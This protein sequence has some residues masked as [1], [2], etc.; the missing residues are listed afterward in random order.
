MEEE[1][2]NSPQGDKE[3]LNEPTAEV[4]DEGV[5]IE[6]PHQE[7][8]D[9]YGSE[10]ASEY[11][12]L[13]S[14]ISIQTVDPST[15]SNPSKLQIL[16]MYKKD[17]CMLVIMSIFWPSCDVY[18]DLLLFIDLVIR[19]EVR[20]ATCLLLPQLVNIILT[21]LLW[22]KLE[23]KE[24]RSWS[25]ILVPLQ[26][27]PQFFALR[28][29]WNMLLG[30]EEWKTSKLTLTNQI[31]TLE[32]YTESLPCVYILMT[33]WVYEAN[34]KENDRWGT[35]GHGRDSYSYKI[36][37]ASSVF[38]IFSSNFGI[39]KFF[40][41]SPVR[42]LPAV[43]PLDGYLAPKTLITFF[44]VLLLNTLKLLYLNLFLRVRVAERLLYSVRGQVCQQVTLFYQSFSFQRE[45]Y[46][47]TSTVQGLCQFEI[48]SPV[49]GKYGRKIYTFLFHEIN[50]DSWVQIFNSTC[51][52]AGTTKEEFNNYTKP[53][54]T[55][56]FLLCGDWMERADI[57]PNL[58]IWLLVFI[59]PH[60]LLS[61]LAL[62][63][64]SGSCKGFTHLLVNQPQIIF[65]PAFS[66][67]VFATQKDSPTRLS[68]SPGFSWV[69]FLLHI[70]SSIA[71]LPLLL[72]LFGDGDILSFQ[73]THRTVIIWTMVFHILS[74]ICLALVLHKPF[75]G[76]QASNLKIF[77]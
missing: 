6:S 74:P 58:L 44:S 20:Y 66:H 72:P 60:L 3:G 52:D 14:S 15:S 17:V 46:N 24:H 55:G 13:E 43:G 73:R 28:I 62:K 36:F 18:S 56:S 77:R 4:S 47:L 32:P 26:A 76:A 54:P 10:V 69:N 22:R 71:V 45:L 37:F 61:L 21:A 25:W 70:I 75:K 5:P 64:I 12:N 1:D 40:K 57:V 7:V 30:K 33:L 34:I 16:L 31:N 29:I 39:I 68:L 50:E 27:W 2:Q 51:V 23:L 11:E 49:R 38:S 65:S 42:F 8:E 35:S 41:S 59:L 67:F 9:V 19:G 53:L 48:F 63:N